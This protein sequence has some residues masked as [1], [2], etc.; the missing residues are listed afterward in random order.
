MLFARYEK[1][2]QARFG[3]VFLENG[4]ATVLSPKSQKMLPLLSYSNLI[5]QYR[6]CRL[7]EQLLQASHEIFPPAND[8]PPHENKGS[9]T[10]KPN[11]GQGKVQRHVV[12]AASMRNDNSRF[13]A[14]VLDNTL[15]IILLL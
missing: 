8:R 11:L 6:K 9:E 15:D 4:K 2:F 13:D 14:M 3:S 1:Y 7:L 10:D 12:W 5:R